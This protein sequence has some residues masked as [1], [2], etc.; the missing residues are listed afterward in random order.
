M[1]LWVLMVEV[2]RELGL[3]RTERKKDKLGPGAA[4]R[5]LV[6]FYATTLEK[7][8]VIAIFTPLHLHQPK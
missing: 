5:C 7:I 8:N 4:Q 6:H 2:E 3:T 1:V